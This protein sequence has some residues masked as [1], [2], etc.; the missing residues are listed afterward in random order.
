MF[1]LFP[2][3]RQGLATTFAG[4]LA[5][6]AP[7]VGP[8]VGGWITDT[9]SWHWLFLI[10]VVPGIISAVLAVCAAAEGADAPARSPNARH[11]VAGPDGDVAGGAGNCAQGG[12]AARLD[13]GA[14]WSD[15]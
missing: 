15:C 14:W 4:V 3:D 2:A 13:L 5:V 6:L 8:V 12:A 11:P 9:Y 1:L 10:N 7:T